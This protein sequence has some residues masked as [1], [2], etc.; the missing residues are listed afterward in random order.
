MATTYIDSCIN[1]KIYIVGNRSVTAHFITRFVSSGLKFKHRYKF[2][3]SPIKKMLNKLLYSKLNLRETV[4]EELYTNDK[5]QKSKLMFKYD[6]FFINNLL[7][8]KKYYFNNI[9]SNVFYA[10][11]YKYVLYTNKIKYLNCSN[12]YFSNLKIKEV[13]IIKK[14]NLFDYYV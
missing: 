11:K 13:L 1:V 12:F 9:L 6:L 4:F 10:N 2:I 3:I 14:N 7:K 5:L 8:N